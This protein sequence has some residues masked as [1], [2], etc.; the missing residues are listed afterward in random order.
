MYQR[1]LI[2]AAIVAALALPSHDLAAQ[3]RDPRVEQR[4]QQHGLTEA[5]V[6]ERLRASGMTRQQA[7]AELQ[8]RGYDPALADYYFD[9]MERDGGGRSRSGAML[10]ALTAAGLARDERAAGDSLGG[11]RAGEEVNVESLLNLSSADLTTPAEG[12]AV[13]GSAFFSRGGQLGQPDFGPAPAGYRLGAGDEVNVILTGAVQDVYPLRVSREGLLVVPDIGEVVVNGLTVGAVEDLLRARFAEVHASNLTR[14]SVSLGRVRSLQVYVIGDVN[15]PGPHQVSGVGTVVSAL[16]GAGGP[17]RTGSYREIEVRRGADVVR[18]VDLYDYL[19]NGDSRADIRLQHGDVLFVP[20]VGRQVTLEGAVRRPGIYEMVDGNGLRDLIRFAG[21]PVAEAALRRVQVDRVLPAAQR[22]SDVARVMVDVDV[23]RLLAPGE[24]DFPL[25]DGDRVR[26]FTVGDERRNVVALV[27][28]VRRPGAY[29]WTPGTTLGDVIDRASGLTDAAYTGR[30][31]VFRLDEATGLRALVSAPADMAQARSI[32]LQDRDSVVVYRR[33]DL[34]PAEY[35][36]VGGLVRSPGR[37]TLNAGASVNDI[38]LKAGGFT[39]GAQHLEAYVARP[40]PLN[41]EAGA[42]AT[43]YRIRLAAD[44]G[45]AVLQPLEW[46]SGNDEFRLQHGDIVEIRRVPGYEPPRT[47]VVLG[48]VALPGTYML[49]TREDRVSGL[50]RAAGG[51]TSEAN[52]TGL[53]VLRRGQVLASDIARG[54]TRAGSEADLVLQHG[55]TVVVPRFD[56]TV[57]VTGAV[58][59]DSTRVLLRPGM[60]VAD[61]V[62][63][64]GGF[65]RDADR[66]KLTVTYQ[67]GAR[68]TVRT[69]PVFRD[70]QPTPEPGSTIYV[71][72][73]PPGTREGP[74]WTTLFSQ[75]IAATSAVATLIIALNQ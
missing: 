20:P 57:L 31:H 18:R 73:R 35:V 38:I 8:R 7:R 54:A 9:A 70:R 42:G 15:R 69:V 5:D 58:V 66:S 47:V 68:G 37:Y 48:E 46:S 63:E 49:E 44:D 45:G 53:H 22:T 67:N 56:P 32:V 50:L 40:N 51:L 11:R 72:E 10:D 12:L 55:D 25:Q 6:I 36:T 4:L 33:T 39:E 71:P 41:G 43:T 19:L 62:R 60:S 74:N 23:A 64:A 16:Y 75:L 13:F 29:G 28:E 14:V 52:A 30:A 65:T 34:R 21:G 2:A 17:S 3:Q 27:G 59:H 61:A 1:W 24:P 26:V